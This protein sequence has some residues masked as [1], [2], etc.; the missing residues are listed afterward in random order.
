VPIARHHPFP[1]IC[2]QIVT[3]RHRLYPIT[4]RVFTVNAPSLTVIDL[5]Q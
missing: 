5:N 3:V 4:P 2:F 1:T